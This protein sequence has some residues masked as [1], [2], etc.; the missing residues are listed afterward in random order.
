[1][2]KRQYTAN[3][4]LNVTD[5]VLQTGHAIPS[6]LP[7]IVAHVAIAITVYSVDLDGKFCAIIAKTWEK[8]Y[9]ET[10]TESLDLL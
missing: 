3:T 5:R 9:P 2:R 10:L 4:S 1:M 8:R 7:R 6:S